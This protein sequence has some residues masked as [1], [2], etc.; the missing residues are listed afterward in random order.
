MTEEKKAEFNALALE[1]LT[2]NGQVYGVPY[3]IENLVL[4]RN[5]DLAPDAPATFEELVATAQEL[6]G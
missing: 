3:A 6:R 4:Y 2:Y 5:T 1:A